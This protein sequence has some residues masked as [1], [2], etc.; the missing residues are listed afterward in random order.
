MKNSGILR[1]EFSEQISHPVN[2][3]NE[4]RE[5]LK[6]VTQLEFVPG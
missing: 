5:F 4:Y 3:T 1:L 2:I 6:E